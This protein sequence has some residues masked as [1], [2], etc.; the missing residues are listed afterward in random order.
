MACILLWSSAVRVHDSQAY[1]KM[2]VTME[3]TSHILEQ[4]G[5]KKEVGRQHQGMD[6]PGVREVPGDS[7]EQGEK[8][9]TGCE[10]ICGDPMT[11]AVKGLMMM[12]Q[13][14]YQST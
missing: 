4:I 13:T 8:E 3:R 14:V 10:I 12:S 2:A 11:L 1:R 6:R 7:G 9:E 5:T